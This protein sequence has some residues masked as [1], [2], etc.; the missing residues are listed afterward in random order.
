MLT[1]DVAEMLRSARAA[2]GISQ[3]ELA[4]RAGVSQRLWSEVER[5]VRPNVSLETALRMLSE[6]GV[7][8]RL[9]DPLGTDRE[10][11]DPAT[12]AAARAARAE[13]RRATWTGRQITL[14][15]EGMEDLSEFSHAAGVERLGA[16]RLVSEQAF[17][18][19]RSRESG[20]RPSAN[21]ARTRTSR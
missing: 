7:T 4:R 19:A 6:V 5:G 21:R 2:L 12:S 8:V 16:V 1:D 9:T 11:R 10:L 14:R 18:V 3:K 13:L 20:P 17:A 15:D